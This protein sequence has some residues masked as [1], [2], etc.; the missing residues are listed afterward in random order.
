MAPTPPLSSTRDRPR[1]KDNCIN[2][3]P[4]RRR[5]SRSLGLITLLN[6]P[7][8]SS[9]DYESLDKIP[10]GEEEEEEEEPTTSSS[11]STGL[12]HRLRSFLPLLNCNLYESRPRV[13]ARG[14]GREGRRVEWRV[15]KKLLPPTPRRYSTAIDRRWGRVTKGKFVKVRSNKLSIVLVQ[16]RHRREF[17]IYIYIFASI[18]VENSAPHI[19]V[20]DL[21]TSFPPLEARSIFVSFENP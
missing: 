9:Q 3:F 2:L 4:I 17:Y 1:S 7:P 10:L 11:S 21:F 13:N 20:R 8:S 15:L 16:L 18:F 14:R 12:V 6:A 19:R 5:N